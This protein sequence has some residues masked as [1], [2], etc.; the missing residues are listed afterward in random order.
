MREIWRTGL[1][2]PTLCEHGIGGK[3]ARDDRKAREKDPAAALPFPEHWN[4]PDVRGALY[5]MHGWVCAYCQCKL[6][7]NDRGDVE[8][9]RPKAG[10]CDYWWLA[11]VFENYL[12]A[13]SK[14]NTDRKGSKFPLTPGAMPVDYANRAA[15]AAE[16]RLLAHPIEDPVESW[17]RVE[18]RDP[19][20]EGEVI[21]NMRVAAGLDP[22]SVDHAR[23]VET[24]G[25]FQLNSDRSLYTERRRKLEKAVQQHRKGG[26]DALRCMASR[27]APFGVFIRGYLSDVAPELVPRPEEELAWFLDDIGER[28]K[29]ASDWC[30]SSAEDTRLAERT[31]EEL[32]WTLAVLWKDPPTGDAGRA[33]VERW[34]ED[35]GYKDLVE[36][37]VTQ[38]VATQPLSVVRP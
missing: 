31:G 8:H 7:R 10:D 33:A 28:L 24:I 25:F 16:A 32:C 1:L 13:C 23:A 29:D 30:R 14:C 6:P 11:Y 5:A 34:L 26:G 21:A 18:W 15:V 2:V 19:D 27:Y 20:R 36:P 35:R 37:L 17:M 12:I 22:G 9:F 38:L 3:R 4:R